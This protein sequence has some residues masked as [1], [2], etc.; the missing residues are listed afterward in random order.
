MGE[1][2]DRVYLTSVVRGY[3]RKAKIGKTGG[4]HLFRH[5][6]ATLMLE[7]GADIR[8]IQET[9][10]TREADDHGALY[11]S[12]DQSAQAGV[13]GHASG[14][15]SEPVGSGEICSRGGADS[16]AR[17]GSGRRRRMIETRPV[18]MTVRENVHQIVDAL[19]EE[20]LEDVLDYLAELSEPDE[21]S[22]ETR[23]AIEEGLDNIRHGRTITLEEYRRTRGL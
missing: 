17:C 18:N 22:A 23:A 3:I 2:F 6:V 19:P 5:T 1:P 20:R 11:A 12:V 4:C 10:R 13:P 9:A 7:N 8:V 15:Q 14:R 16:R 21:L